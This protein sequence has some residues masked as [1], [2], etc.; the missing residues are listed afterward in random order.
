MLNILLKHE[1]YPSTCSSELSTLLCYN[2]VY[3]WNIDSTTRLFFF[4]R[5]G[6]FV[7]NTT[8]PIILMDTIDYLSLGK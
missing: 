4:T 6:Y 7:E 2:V 5:G 8:F 1:G 3:M